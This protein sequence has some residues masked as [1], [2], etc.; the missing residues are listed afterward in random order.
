MNRFSVI[1]MSLLSAGLFYVIPVSADVYKYVAPDGKVYYTDEPKHSKYKRIIRTRPI[2]YSASLKY[3]KKNREKYSPAIK[4]IAK[5]YQLDSKLLHAMIHAESAY[6]PKAV[7]SAGA[8]GMMQLMPNTAKRYGVTDRR[9]PSQN[10]EGGARY[11]KDLLKMF[12]SNLKLAVAAYNAGE[13]AVKKYH[14]SIPPYPETQ[15][16][17]KK[18][19]ALYRG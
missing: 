1:L 14:N 16:Y 7:S 6:D 19:L 18:V 5:K 9:N 3:L 2:N 11:M 15:A 10:I 8:V 4:T 13:N 17:V 12:N